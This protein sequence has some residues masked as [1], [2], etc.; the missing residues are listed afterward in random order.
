MKKDLITRK[1]S[2]RYPGLFVKKYTRR[3]FFDNLWHENAKLLESR[4]HVEDANGDVV[5]NPLTKIFNH[6]E[7]DTDID[8]DELC[9][10]VRKVNGFMAAATYVPSLGKVVVSTTGSLDSDYVTLAEKYLLVPEVEGYI[11]SYHPDTPITWV[12]E[13]C[14]PSD[15]HIVPEEV[16]AWLLG[17]RAVSNP[18]AYCSDQS[19]EMLLDRDAAEMSVRRPWW[20]LK[21][22]RNIVTDA[23]ECQHEGFVVYGQSSGTA[24]KIKSPYYKILKAVARRKDIFSLNKERVEEEF[25]DL[26]GHL[27]SLGESFTIMSEQERLDYMRK[28]LDE[29]LHV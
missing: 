28:Y 13:I 7:N 10:A 17:A 9:I 25:F 4:G 5:I 21:S 26:V 24:L 27:T 11:A 8:L 6:G 19:N 1:E 18:C 15:P 29:T 3:V 16:G 22:F 12:F 23:K 20:R 14:D 2:A